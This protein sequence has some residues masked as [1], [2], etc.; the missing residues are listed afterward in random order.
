[1]AAKHERLLRKWSEFDAYASGFPLSSD[2]GLLKSA[3]LT[4]GKCHS[5]PSDSHSTSRSSSRRKRV[6]CDIALRTRSFLSRVHCT[7]GDALSG[8]PR[9]RARH[10]VRS[11]PFFQLQILIRHISLPV[12]CVQL[13]LET[14]LSCA[15]LLSPPPRL[16]TWPQPPRADCSGISFTFTKIA[17]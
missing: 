11:G 13:L 3:C 8:A 2:S 12:L 1:M 4:T 7:H 5:L 17:M 15:C 10:C 6:N 9:R 16:K 14:A